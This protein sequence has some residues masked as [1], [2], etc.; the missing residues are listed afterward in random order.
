MKNEKIGLAF[1]G[2]LLNPCCMLVGNYELLPLSLLSA[3]P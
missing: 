1:F 2:L 3:Y